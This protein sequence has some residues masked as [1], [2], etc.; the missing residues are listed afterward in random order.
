MVMKLSKLANLVSGFRKRNNPKKSRR[1][2]FRASLGRN[3]EQLESRSLLATLAQGDIAILSINSANPDT[4]R[5]T[6]LV[7][8]DSGDVIN[9]TDNGF[10]AGATG[11][12]GEG[13][14]TFTAN[15]N[16]PTGSI[17][18]WTNGMT[19]A[20]TPWSSNNPTNFAFN[21]NGD[22][23]FAFT[24]AT[25]SWA[26]QAGVTLLFGMNFGTALSATSSASNTVQPTALTTAFL[27]LPTSTNANTYYSGNGSAATSVTLTGSASQILGDAVTGSKWFGNSAA[28][29]TFPTYTVTVGGTNTPP[30]IVNNSAT[31]LEG[32]TATTV[33][34]TALSATDGEQ[35]AA[36]LTFTLSSIP[37]N[38]TVFK[39][40]TPLAINGTFTQADVDS[41]LITYTH[42]GSETTSD[43]FNFTVS[44]GVGGSVNSTFN[45]TITPVNDTP[46]LTN[47]T[48]LGGV[49]F[50]TTAP[51]ASA[52]LL[53][54]DVDNTA[55]QIQYTLTSV[56]TG[57]LT[58]TGTGALSIGSTFTQDD[59]NT[60]KLSYTAPASGTNTSFNFTVSD[61][62]G[63]AIGST[64]F[65]IS[66]S[67][68][69]T[70]PT[71]T[72]NTGLTLDEAGTATVTNTQLLVSDAEQ[73]ATSLTFTVTA[74]PAN[75]AL[76]KSGTPLAVNGT[77]TQADINSNLIT[78]LH[79]GSETTTDSFTFTVSDGS[80]GSIGSTNF[81][82]TINPVND[83]PELSTNLGLTVAEG[84][85]ATTIDNTRLTVSDADNTA[86]QV[87]F[88]LATI[89]AGGVLALNGTPLAVA[90]TFTQ[91]D[92]NN[93]VLSYAHNGGEAATD[94]FT[95]TVSDGAG[96][97]IATSTFAITVTPVA[98]PPVL[99]VNRTLV[100][101][102]GQ[103]VTISGAVL[104]TSDPDTAAASL[105]YTVGTGPTRGTLTKNAVAVTSFTQG[106]LN[107]SDT[108]AGSIRYTATTAVAGE[109]DSF[110]FTVTDGTTPTASVTFN[111]S[112]VAPTTAFGF[113]GNYSQS[114]DNLLPSPVP[115]NNLSIPFAQ[116]LPQGWSIVET[117]TNFNNNLR[118]DSGSQ[119]TGDSFLYGALSSNER[120]L[121]SQGSG[122]LT[123]A[124]MGVALINN[125]S[126]TIT[127]LD[128]AYTG[129]LWRNGVANTVNTM[130]FDYSTSA[131]DIGTGTYTGFA[132]LNFVAPEVATLNAL[133]GNLPANQVAVSGTLTGFSWAPG[134]TIF[135]RWT[136]TDTT[137]NDDGLAIDDLV[138]T[139][140]GSNTEPVANN[141]TV[142]TNE[143][144]SVAVTLTATDGENDPLT[145]TVTTGPANGT[146]T[147]TAPN[148][149]YV[150][151]ADFFGQ[152]TFV[153][154]A[155]D[156]VADS[157]L[158]TVTINVTA[159]NDAP[160]A[161]GQTV[162]TNE[163]SPVAVTLT[164]AD[165][166]GDSLTYT[167]T[168]NPANGT[169]SGTA[170]NLTF[171]PNA[172]FFGQ[173]LIVFKVN[174]G[175]VDSGL[176]TVTVNV[177]A[178]NDAPTA[179]GQTV[180]TNEDTSVGVTLT[181][182]DVD[183]DS[184]TYSI[185]TG[186]TNGTLTG[187]APNLT[188]I[189]APNYFGSDSI[190][191]K[192][193]DGTV[194]SA[195]AT[196]V[197]NVAAVNDAPTAN[198][199]TV[200]T[201]EDSPVSVT[202]TGADVDGNSLTYTVTS[203]PANGTLSGTAPNLTFTPNA[204]FFGQNLIVFKVNDGTVDSA[205]ATVTVNVAAVNDAPTANAQTVNVVQDT[206]K[207]VTLTGADI[208]GDTLTYVVVGSPSNGSLSGS[209]PNLTYTP[210]SGYTG[211]DSF[212]FKVNDGTID[213]SVVTV[214][215]N[216]GSNGVVNGTAGLDVFTVTR[217]GGSF[218]VS[219]VSDGGAPSNLGSFGNGTPIIVN[220]LGGSDKLVFE[221]DMVSDAATVSSTGV[222]FNGSAFTLNSVENLT[223]NLGAGNDSVS[224]TGRPIPAY[225]PPV[226]RTPAANIMLIAGGADNDTYS[227]DGDNSLGT[228]ILDE[229][230][231]GVDTVSLADTTGSGVT[232]NLSSKILQVVNANLSLNLQSGTTFE[233]A[234]G[235]LGNDM[236]TGNLSANVLEGRAGND[237]LVGMTGNDRYVFDSMPLSG[238]DTITDTSGIDTID[239]RASSMAITVNLLTTTAQAVNANQ[240]IVLGSSIIEGVVGSQANDT[241]VGNNAS[242]F[243]EG[244]GGD[245]M[246][247]GGLGNDTYVFNA[248][249]GIGTDTINDATGSD[250]LDFSPTTSMGVT[251]SLMTSTV[252]AVNANLSLILT[253]A[254]LLD[255]L[256]G[257]QANDT[258]IGHN[259][260]N[261]LTGMGG[262]DLLQGGSGN[263]TYWFKSDVPMGT[264][265]IDD[266]VG[267]LD[268][269]DFS[270]SV[271]GITV[272]MNLTTA[273][274]VTPNLSLIFATNNTIENVTGSA[275]A[276]TIVGNALNNKIIG[277][278]GDDNLNGGD[279]NDT[280]VWDTDILQLGTDTL[281]DT[282][283][284]DLFDFSLTTMRQI[285]IN[286]GS[287]ATQVVNSNLS[288]ILSSATAFDNITG[289]SLNDSL[290]GNANDNRF[291]GRG[292]DDM[293]VGG[294]GNDSYSFDADLPIG[295][296]TLDESAGGLDTID[297]T[298]TTTTGISINLATAGSQAIT[299][300]MNL[301]LGAGNTFERVI[302][303]S[304]DDTIVG[305][306][307]DNI[308]MGMNGNDTINGDSG[309]DMLIGGTGADA[310]TGGL[311][312][313]LM[314]AGTTSY[315]AI[316]SSLYQ[317]FNEW[318]GPNSYADRVNNLKTGTGVPVFA[319][320]TQVKKDTGGNTLIGG[321]DND[322]YF[323]NVSGGTDVTDAALGEILE[324]L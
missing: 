32:V 3:M 22:Q 188:Y 158:A 271:V 204:N 66:L 136:D 55:A 39:S 155:N 90:G 244:S 42:N 91:A 316:Q 278:A 241:I 309:R 37:A 239:F 297:F 206:P 167:V 173:N 202:L 247:E 184:L 124:R 311:G 259:L 160:T 113:S 237:T 185:V 54:S 196:V 273:Q 318:T 238:T 17:F 131:T 140:T 27:N 292:G 144:N 83:N 291:I 5:F 4:F 298:G 138:I 275:F 280:Y 192:V 200:S 222:V 38:G 12:T 127:S 33:A 212:T 111:I 106:D 101:N 85:T 305:N 171:T 172:N 15:Q 67:A 262:D 162:S 75:G 267:V 9:F 319:K 260:V 57:T 29:T 270:S 183:G 201:N 161:N 30:T 232:L 187:T 302:G 24:G 18:T 312:E 191:F 261:R 8:L 130:T 320:T 34:N 135:L 80:T 253:T 231:G 190:V 207:S 163:D 89:P 179:N 198:S 116:V 43:S 199:Q 168:S 103:S 110:T 287:I 286:L 152:D 322:Y 132:A 279:G 166:D 1:D 49:V 181:G 195:V 304:L 169:L 44:D 293:L 96:G 165:V 290:I 63:G 233:N 108:L 148:V 249:T 282:N 182:A 20:G 78:Y 142:S 99:S 53:V 105:A 93:N 47:N 21:G 123:Q 257:S 122:S 226:G 215:I 209:A 277:G 52:N 56:P 175:T 308:L 218:S 269:I 87:T 323:A 219:L 289:G 19:I 139:A 228:V 186:P 240:T 243:L 197:I 104:S 236:L 230:A 69:N 31:Y 180:S 281:N 153:F 121:G 223:L 23:L 285:S 134:S 254:S 170:P 154:K 70:A 310:L 205:L 36:Q 214:T 221:G 95:F 216:V 11:R 300:S 86:S 258:L 117:G 251:V 315:D 274:T 263:D 150:P 92:I 284:V 306:S 60:G 294:L 307:L 174:D 98:D 224:V 176:A 255:N 265:T 2:V 145:Y 301:I 178:A 118:V 268:V 68:G 229:A 250:T 81:A 58:R 51:I 61:G 120:G 248:N 264:D 100:L 245:D 156:G 146:L 62:A 35:S 303:S 79:S 74:I 295:T 115:G 128:V 208:D 203:G 137:G 46:T 77:F 50:N 210:N 109:T 71:L 283:G 76:R 159:V 125:T 97:S 157:N 164:G 114:F 177:A 288:V 102:P 25:G 94:N 88:T 41:N 107:A 73:N 149:T 40:G 84:A 141:Q 16:Y 213:S 313:D 235:G 266:S 65:T 28:A 246:L 59:I 296:D 193:N 112:I 324:D 314:I 299:G 147:G 64:T 26:S 242:N 220:G 225:A 227:F 45:V 119:A 189:P 276:D 7:A 211:S 126:S 10:T 272:D 194:D 72:N 317:V 129:E 256:V 82:F 48:G 217:S 13:F 14:L 234:I 252:Q 143:D 6:N 151:N 321:L 133:D